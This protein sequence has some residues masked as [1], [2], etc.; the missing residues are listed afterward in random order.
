MSDVRDGVRAAERLMQAGDIDG[1]IDAFRRVLAVDPALPDAWYNLGYLLRHAGAYQDALD[2][3]A[4]ALARG[5][6]GAHEVHINRAAILSE[7][8]NRTDDAEAELRAA[9]AVEPRAALAWLNLGS[10]AEDR[11]DA[12]AARDGY[13]RAL[14]IAPDLARAEARIATLDVLAGRA[15]EV[16]ARLRARLAGGG[17]DADG[18]S[19][20]GFA[21]AGALDVL[22]RDTEAF[23]ALSDANRR[24]RSL[25][26]P[27]RRYDAGAQRRL[28]DA[29]LAQPAPAATAP[30]AGPDTPIFIC[31]MFRSG[32][33]LAEQL[34]VRHGEGTI[35]GGEMEMIPALVA[36]ALQPYPAALD[37]LDRDAARA[38]QARYVADMRALLPGPA[39]ATDKRCD[40]VF[41]IGL[42][43]RLFPDAKIVHTMRSPLDTILSV[44]FLRF[45]DAIAYNFD[46]DEIADFYI[47]YRR[48]IDHWRALFPGDILELD[49]DALVGD[50]QPVLRRLVAELGL[51][52]RAGAPAAAADPIRTASAWQVRQPV[53]A[54]SSGRWRRYAP[55]LEGVRARLLA[56]GIDAG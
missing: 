44:F 30:P 37:G 43:K 7:A 12:E 32:S 38:L 23:A 34:I 8:L 4:E 16:V 56:A 55:W 50:P 45:S 27:G 14:A 6:R 17:V 26:A 21:L 54:R 3:Y 29:L 49:Y 51:E 36:R 52:W 11:G 41:H 15:E 28:V 46:L 1:S 20:L 24:A 5:V 2:A 9:V 22:G 19:D 35:A 39:R 40:N 25:L 18:A 48:A 13:K 53:H 10:L 31:G 47:Q 42:I 33:T